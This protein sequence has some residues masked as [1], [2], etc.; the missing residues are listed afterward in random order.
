MRMNWWC[1][2]EVIC[3]HAVPPYGRAPQVPG[4]IQMLACRAHHRTRVPRAEI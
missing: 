2:F 3:A 1:L 4:T